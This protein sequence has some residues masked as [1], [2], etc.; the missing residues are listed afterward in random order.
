M[1]LQRLV[2]GLA[3]VGGFN[4]CLGQLDPMPGSAVLHPAATCRIDVV[5]TKRLAVTKLDEMRVQVTWR[6]G[7]RPS[8]SAEVRFAC[9]SQSLREE[10]DAA[11]FRED[12]G[13]WLYTGGSAVVSATT[14]QA[15]TWSGMAAT[16]FATAVCRAVI[17]RAVTGKSVFLADFCVSE[18]DYMRDHPA[19]EMVEE[20][21]SIQA[22]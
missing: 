18:A 17:G 21:I 6:V 1:T 20:Q 7:E 13:R 11:G 10:L 2:L 19:L 12:H 14:I 22:Q 5:P 3:L 16:Y 4:S 8:A 15:D 9:S